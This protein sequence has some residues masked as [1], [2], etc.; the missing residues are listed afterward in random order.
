M[1]KQVITVQGMSC[2]HCKNAVEKA[3]KAL[4][5]VSFAEVD[6]GAKSLTVQFEATKVSI[7]DIKK[8][9]EEEGFTV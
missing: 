7:A 1:E 3:V 8:A 5:G 2:G 6:L 4:P 9:V